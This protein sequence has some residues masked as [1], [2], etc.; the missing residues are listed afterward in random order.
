MLTT[1]RGKSP[2]TI[3]RMQKVLA[4]LFSFLSLV[5]SS[6][7][8]LWLPAWGKLSSDEGW[9]VSVSRMLRN[10]QDC[11]ISGQT[12]AVF[13]LP[14]SALDINTF[15]QESS[16]FEPMAGLN[17][18][19]GGSAFNETLDNLRALRVTLSIKVVEHCW[20]AFLRFWHLNDYDTLEQNSMKWTS[21]RPGTTFVA[22][23]MSFSFAD[24]CSENSGHGKGAWSP[25]LLILR[26][27]VGEWLT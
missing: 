25:L 8:F 17:K 9:E 3:A 7:A 19:L 11:P 24:V 18:R 23:S 22:K 13:P 4:S 15:I 21:L 6:S 26:I 1:R 5:S 12:R 10:N 2:R 14:F 20:F 27:F 16:F